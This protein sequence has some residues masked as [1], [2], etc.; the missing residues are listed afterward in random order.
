MKIEIFN[1]DLEK[2]IQSL[3]KSTI[4]KTLRTIDLLE[5]FGYNLKLPHSKKVAKNLFEL[6]INGQQ[7]IR[8]FYI[9]HNSRIILLRGFIKKSQKI[10]P[11]EIQLALDFAKRFN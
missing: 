5:R 6:R 3:E 7:E 1:N 9:F 4:A 8:V 2:F 11:K 10:P